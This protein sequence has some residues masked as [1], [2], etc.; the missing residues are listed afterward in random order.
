VD[1][2]CMQ[3]VRDPTQYDMLVRCMHLVHASCAQS[4]CYE[5]YSRHHMLTSLL[6]L[7]LMPNLYVSVLPCCDVPCP[8]CPD[9]S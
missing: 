3:L 2:A 1:N 8:V 9:T 4:A 5:A 7:Q 6:Q